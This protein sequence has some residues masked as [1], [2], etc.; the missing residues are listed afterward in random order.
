MNN[1]LEK[2]EKMREAGSL[3]SKT[4]DMITDYIKPG[5]STN[6]LDS[7]CYEFIKDSGGY[8]APLYYRGFDKSICTSLNHVVCHG[9]PSKRVLEDGDILNIDVTAVFNNHYG[10]TSRMFTVGKPSVKSMNLINVTYESLMNA[11]KI[12]KPGRKLG[13]IGYEIQTYVEK[14]GFSVVRDFCG[15]GI[16]EIFHQ[17]PNVLHYGKKDTGIEL[18]PGMTFTIEP[19]I[20]AGKYDVKVLNDGWTAVTKDKLLSAQFEHTVGITDNGYEIFTESA[21]NLN[22]PPYN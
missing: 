14:A 1:F 20:N 10:D 18:Q 4:L 15:H 21:K 9:I 17:S 5:V 11:I 6:K 16:G 19:M 12:L 8:S 7:L 13:D 3:A 2:F 22:R